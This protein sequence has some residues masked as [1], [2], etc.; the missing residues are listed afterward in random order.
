MANNEV[1]SFLDR[2][3]RAV[4]AGDAKAIAPMW[5]LPAMVLGDDMAQEVESREQVEQFFGGAKAQYNQ[6]GIVDTRA[7]IISLEWPTEKICL[8]EVRWPYLDAQDEEIGEESS[9]YIL[10]RDDG[11]EL[12]LRGVI[13]KG[14]KPRH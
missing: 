7:E 4:T 3:A 6:R 13:F 9:I 11:G 10:R 8:V 14:E 2:F 5:D 12:K 1:Q